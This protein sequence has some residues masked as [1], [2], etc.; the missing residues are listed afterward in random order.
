MRCVK[1]SLEK[2]LVIWKRTK[3]YSFFPS[4]D[5]TSFDNELKGRC[6]KIAFFKKNPNPKKVL[7]KSFKKKCNR[8]NF[9]PKTNHLKKPCWIKMTLQNNVFKKHFVRTRSLSSEQNFHANVLFAL[10]KHAFSVTI[11]IASNDYALLLWW[12]S[13]CC[14]LSLGSH[15]EL[16]LPRFLNSF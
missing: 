2:K 13:R 11:E 1:T 10:C 7:G 14:G 6:S 16:A 9:V 12:Y 5:K 15:G 4:L 8:K 3:K